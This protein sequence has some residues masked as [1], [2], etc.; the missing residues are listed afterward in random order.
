MSLKDKLNQVTRRDFLKG[1]SA[2]GATA[3][4]YGCGGSG[5]GG[6]T[7]MEE[8]EENRPSA[9]SITETVIM[10]AT[11]HNCGGRCVSKYYVKDGVVKRITTDERGDKGIS[12]GDDPEYRSCVRCRSRKQWFYRNDRLLYPLKQ[13]GERG[14]INGFVRISWEQAFTE[15]AQ[16]MQSIKAQ[17]GAAAFHSIYSSG[18]STGWSR[19]SLH[20]ML[21]LNGG[22]SYYYTNYSFPSLEHMAKFMEGANEGTPLGNGRQ[23]AKFADKLVLWSFNPNETVFGTNTGWYLQQIKELGKE[24]ISVDSR[25]SKATATSADTYI[26]L[27]PGTDA[28][29]LSGMIYH[30]L[31]D[32][33]ADLDIPWINARMYGLFDNGQSLLRSDVD[34]ARYAIPDGGSLSAFILGDENDLVTAGHN[35]GTSIYPDTIGYEVNDDDPLYGKTVSIWGQRAKT[36]EWAEKI[37]GVPAQTIRDL[38]DM[39][40]DNKVTTW[41]GGGYQRHT[42]GEQAI[43]LNRVL[44]VMTKNIGARGCSSGRNANNKSASLPNVQMSR[45][46]TNP[47][48]QEPDIYDAT[49]VTSPLTYVHAVQRKNLPVFVIPDAVENAAYPGRKSKWNDGQVNHVTVPYK[50]VFATGGNIMVNQS[51]DVNYNMAIWKDRSKAELLVNCDHFLTPSA[52]IAD[53]VLPASMIGEKPGAVN[54]WGTGEVA[55]KINKLVDAPGEVISEYE[56][57]EGIAT[58]FGKGAEYL[59]GYASGQEGMEARLRDGWESGNLTATYG[60]SYDEWCEKGVASLH[61][62][63]TEDDYFIKHKAFIENP[64]LANALLTPTGKIE[65]YCMNL[66]EDYEARYHDNVDT[67]TSDAGGQTTLYNGGTIYSAQHGDSTARRFVYPI[68]MYIPTIEGRHAI[69]ATNPNDELAHDDPLGIRTTYPFTLHTWHLMYRSHS[70]LNNVAY[71]NE[72]YKQD[73]DGN[74]AFLD[75]NRDWTDGVWDDNVYETVVMNPAHAA[76][77]GLESGD[78][79]L[80]SNDRG[81]IYASVRFSQTVPPHTICIGQGAWSKQNSQGID[82]GGNANTVVT[83]RPSRICKGMTSATD[84]RVKIVKA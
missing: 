31:T 53:Y 16:K 66:M 71:L 36:P 15:I 44:S 4:V 21:M 67:V 69:D 54:A 51:G 77:L 22:Y 42:E 11:P 62:T 78:R 14:D 35:N 76:S 72:Q 80:I 23:D 34:V 7:Y 29:L 70:T 37:C 39:Y 12:N 52:A 27:L 17:Y 61:T 5:S 18:D 30:L 73:I 32:R 81:K 75:P 19:N 24:I 46:V 63:Y 38:A 43:W 74:A 50:A 79:V 8:D 68:G 45:G 10:G 2:V 64:V 48:N 28:A 26:N 55:I 25:Y 84:S 41:I 59:D 65:A 82:V 33:I 49:R 9:P 3:A 83:A 20:R 47:V 57:F 1:V 58:A 6:K 13:T 60:M 56:I 40:L